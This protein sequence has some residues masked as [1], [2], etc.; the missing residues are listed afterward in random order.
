MRR[1]VAGGPGAAVVLVALTSFARPALA[2]KPGAYDAA[3]AGLVH[4]AVT[5]GRRGSPITITVDVQ[6]EL[7]F[8]KLVLA[9]RPEGESE[10]RGREM[11]LVTEGTYR[12]EIPAQGTLGAT[13]A[14][15]IEAQDKDGT[16][17]AGRASAQSPLVI[18]LAGPAPSASATAGG[19][20]DEEADVPAR[21][22]F[23]ALLV[24]GGAGWARGDGDTNADTRL[25]PP[26]IA[27]AGLGQLV[28][29]V[30]YWLTSTF[31]VSLQGRFEIVG[32][33][34]TDVYA[35]G[36]VYHVADYA[37]AGFVKGTWLVGD[38]RSLHPFFS[39][40][41]GL[42][43]IRHVVTFD[44]L[45]SCGPSQ[46]QTCVDT[47]ATGPVAVGPGGGIVLDFTPSLAGVLELDTQLTFPAY[48]INVDANLGFAVKF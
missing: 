42:G 14:Y 36:R 5:L 32:R 28:P 47:I 29:E 17:V 20:E 3:P 33:G 8:A 1:A 44:G 26:S 9:Y 43:R 48:S 13:V 2:Q 35:N 18:E 46:G 19:E 40:A 15:F 34:P 45:K 7:A 22:F 38:G 24:G 41:A 4:E 6:N 21:R 16:P 11:T 31:L 39:L 37:A 10:F 27:R 12:A 30:G 25:E 23:V